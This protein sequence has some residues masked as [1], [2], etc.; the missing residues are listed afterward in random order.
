MNRVID[1]SFFGET[2]PVIEIFT[3]DKVLILNFNFVTNCWLRRLLEKT[4]LVSF[5]TDVEV[6]GVDAR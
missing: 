4:V 1:V 2:L 3:K 6:D 5:A